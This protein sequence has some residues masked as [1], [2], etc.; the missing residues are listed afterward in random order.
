MA[1][2][3][4]DEAVPLPGFETLR[5]LGRGGMGVVYLARQVSLNRQVAIKILPPLPRAESA[6]RAE[7]FRREAE[8]MARV[9]HPNVV[10]VYDFG[11][12][13]GRPYLVMEFVA[14]GDLKRSISA[15]RPLEPGRVRGLIA[16]IARA[17]TCLHRAGILHRD[18][19]P[20]NILMR[21]GQT[22]KV[23]DFGIAVPGGWTGI[24]NGPAPGTPGYVAPE[25]QY[26]LKVDERCDQYSLAAV[27]YELLTGRRPLGTSFEPPSR[28]HRGLSKEVDEAIMRGLSDDRDDRFGTVEEFAE[29]LDRALAGSLQPRPRRVW[30]AAAGLV[31]LALVAVFVVFL[32]RPRSPGTPSHLGPVQAPDRAA[33]GV[34]NGAK[35]E[36]TDAPKP[37]SPL[38]R[39]TNHL[40][41]TMLL[42]KHGDFTMGSPPEDADAWADE[43][44]QHRV[45][46][47]LPFY[48]AE[49]EVTNRQF[50]S[51]VEATGYKTEA[52]RSGLGGN[53][54]DAKI[55][56]LTRDPKLTFRMPSYGRAAADDEPV[57]QVTWN[58]SRAF[59][60]W[61]AKAE[62]M[63]YRLPSEAEWEYACR[64]GT[65]T[66]W[67]TGK[68]PATLEDAAWTIGNA[69]GRLHPVGKKKPNPWGLR[70]MHGN[71]WEWCD[72]W[73]GGYPAEPVT[74]PRGLSRGDKKALRGGSWDYDTVSRTSSASRLP[75][76][77]D[78]P[79][80]TH[81]FRVA[82]GPTTRPDQS[83][84]AR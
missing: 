78:R 11:V 29:T 27:A 48:L 54:Y 18:L 14:G 3:V 69:G 59:C 16:P 31:A 35:A 39:F 66:R 17:L 43:R 2:D 6:A 15:D 75:D 61:L 60:D 32:A 8:L 80:F 56:N 50:R 65:T 73:F 63:P 52:E 72:D 12:A 51:F 21:D 40:G 81:G 83:Q 42:I 13:D 45:S 67:S 23:A 28:Y 19:K 47:T 24:G 49:C 79:H 1:P 22:P 33:G 4:L 9:S 64:A 30:P 76:P 36:K 25:Q 7:T 68:D 46:L 37:G 74:D 20:A 38:E 5:R 58:D 26:G 41:M 34:G 53:I 44:P 71:A 70:D 10:S 55:K 57:V 77:P 84:G 82:M 62:G